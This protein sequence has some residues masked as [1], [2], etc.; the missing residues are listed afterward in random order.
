MVG[1]VTVGE[2][3]ARWEDEQ[4]L[5]IGGCVE[6]AQAGRRICMT[7]GTE[8]EGEVC[9]RCQEAWRRLRGG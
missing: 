1:D 5:L 9:P 3:L 6:E 8:Y 4:V 7:C 2:W